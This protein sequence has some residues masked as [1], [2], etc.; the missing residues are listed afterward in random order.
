MKLNMPNKKNDVRKKAVIDVGTRE[1]NMVCI[2]HLI[3]KVLKKNPYIWWFVRGL[4]IRKGHLQREVRKGG[5]YYIIGYND[6]QSCGWTVWERVVLYGSMY[7][8]DYGM[9]PVVD[10]QSRKNIYLEE[11]EVGRVNAWE[12]YY[13]QPGGV[14]LKDAIESDDYVL[15]DSSQEWFCYI[16]ERHPGKYSDNEFLRAQ[17]NKYVRLKQSIIDELD[18][19]MKSVLPKEPVQNPRLL[20]ICLRGTDYKTFHHMKQ[21]EIEEVLKTAKRIFVQYQCDYYYVATEDAE[22]YE[23]I[24]KALPDTKLVSYN[25]GNI[26]HSDGLIGLQI[27]KSKCANEAAMDYLTT[28]CIMNQSVA[29]IGGLCGATIVAKY[30]RKKPYEYINIINM[31]DV[32]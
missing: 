5:R 13:F 29:L 12:K 27:R 8:S 28:L 31:H 22:I 25:A 9:I 15:A 2:K 6:S 20:A 21:P 7:A 17:F 1:G 16:R 30:R 23:S 14:L 11:D 18:I 4:K 10:M 24:K 3:E 32:Y 26:R 19:R